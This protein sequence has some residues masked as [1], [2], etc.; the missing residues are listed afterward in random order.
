MRPRTLICLSALLL[1]ASAAA[2]GQKIVYPRPVA[3]FDPG[4]IQTLTAADP[5]APLPQLWKE[6]EA[7]ATRPVLAIR[8]ANS[9][10]LSAATLAE[11]QKRGP[12]LEAI[13]VEGQGHAP[14]LETGDLPERIAAF[15]DRAEGK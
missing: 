14:F 2:F 5:N 15:F 6:F 3:D 13:T 4:L 7:L 12:Q 9:R 10:L 8:G 11:M 1:V